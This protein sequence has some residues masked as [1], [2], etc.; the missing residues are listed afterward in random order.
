MKIGS[1]NDLKH[2][3]E[4]CTRL[5][6]IA[7]PHLYRSLL[8]CAPGSSLGNLVAATEKLPWKHL[9]YTQELGFRIPVHERIEARC[10]HRDHI[11]IFN[12][13]LQHRI[14]DTDD[15]DIDHEDMDSEDSDEDR[16]SKRDKGNMNDFSSL[17]CA[18]DSMKFP[19]DQLQSFRLV[20]HLL[21]KTTTYVYLG[22]S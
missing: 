10:L 12:E 2:L 14:A 18:L 6:A 1:Q 20:Q 17:M 22:G 13:S 16:N 4:V 19:D 7:L 8:L 11:G 3:C 21:S 5:Y 15:G 9:E